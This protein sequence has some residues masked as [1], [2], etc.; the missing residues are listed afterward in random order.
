MLQA[1]HQQI[2][3]QHQQYAQAGLIPPQT[4]LLNP[5]QPQLQPPPPFITPYGQYS[6]PSTHRR[7]QSSI[8]PNHH[9]N[10]G[11]NNHQANA[12][13]SSSSGPS[14]GHN[15][16]HSLALSEAKQAAAIAQ[17]KRSN[18]SDTSSAS[19]ETPTSSTSDSKPNIPSF[20]FPSSP[21]KPADTSSTS[22]P[23][24]SP[25][26]HG[27]SQSLQYQRS[28]TRNTSPQRSYQFPATNNTSASEQQ[29]PQ[30]QQQQDFSRSHQHNRSGSRNFDG[31]WRQ[32]HQPQPSQD[33]LSAPFVPGHR[34]RGSYGNSV[35]SIQAYGMMNQPQFAPNGAPGNQQQRKSLFSPY[36]PQASL[37]AL[38]AEGRLVS[39]ILRVNKKNRSDAYVS[40]DGLLDAD[41][42]ICGSKDRNRALEGDL[43]AVELLEVDE[44]WTSKKEK[45]EKKKRKDATIN[46]VEDNR[47]PLSENGGLRRRGSLK[48]R[49]T[50][51]KNDDVEVEGQ[52]L[53]LVEEEA[54]SD[55]VKPLY[56]GHVVAIIDRVPA[57]TFSGT[58]GLLRPSSQATK[59][60]QDAERK[61]RGEGPSR[62][63]QDKPKIVWF[64][65]TDKRVPLIAIPT[66][67]A[68]SDF[69]EN[70]ESYV[71]KIF[72]ASIKR[73][74]IT[75]L[76]PFGTMGSL[77]GAAGD[78]DIEIEAL[79]RD[80]NFP[81]D[82]FSEQ[83]LSSVPQSTSITEEDLGKR[84]NLNSEYVLGFAP[85]ENLVEQAFHVTKIADDKV[86]I[87]I[88]VVDVSHYVEENSPLDHEARKRG[89]SV[90]LKQ[91][92]VNQFPDKFNEFVSFKAGRQSLALSVIFD[93]DPKTFIISDTW[94]GETIVTPSKI[95]PYSVGQSVLAKEESDVAVSQAEINYIHT[96]QAVSNKFR[97]QRL[98]L[99]EDDKAP[100]HAL[101]NYVDDENVVVS[102]NIFEGTLIQQLFDEINIKV[103]TAVAQKL[104]ATI[105][106]KAF[107]RRHA[108]PIL[109][110]IEAFTESVKNLNMEVDTATSAT[111][112][113]SFLS[114]G[115]AGIRKGLEALLYKCMTRAKYFIA[116]K[117]DA[118]NYGH[119]FF[120]VPVYTHFNAPLR[121]YADIVV[122]RQL[123][124]IINGVPY[125]E[126]IEK[127][128]T[129]ADIC[130][131]K[132][133]CAK[134]AQEQSIH[135]AVCQDIDKKTV[136]TGQLVIDSI[137]IQV[138]ESAFDV[139]IP[140]YGIEKRVHGDQLPLRKAEFDKATRLLELY[141]EGGID[142]AM[143]V[144]DNEKNVK[145]AAA[146]TPVRRGRVRASSAASAL[147]QESGGL[148]SIS[149]LSINKDKPSLDK[150]DAAN[151]SET[152][153]KVLAPY[154]ENVIKREEN[155]ERVQEIRVLQHV[156]VLLSAEL[157]NSI[158]CL[159]VRAV[160]PFTQ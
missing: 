113:K 75:S 79:L 82:I 87:G 39:G 133:D 18:L 55:E 144:P 64:K 105:G 159:T 104:V 53:L 135:L 91:R 21:D 7:V 66:D 54:L 2:L 110:K 61:D 41:I 130:N 31:N 153:G 56:A 138:Y 8:P 127:L 98:G 28:F 152:A 86:E 131:F 32:S 77:L 44:V 132:K 123:K 15:R 140:E 148:E 69:V 19:P 100:V 57:Q 99:D 85:K 103:N 160:N 58:L 20:K 94:I 112:Q 115:D 143:Y 76:H 29:Q 134:N 150:S 80:N 24:A 10:S 68:P 78:E 11:G 157:G 118:D 107:L 46:S 156:P 136:A 102:S 74:P 17:A 147:A 59:N 121:R 111:I 6:Q 14:L 4:N 16:R 146:V 122:H 73:W 3:A 42:F 65:P 89:T 5:Q 120:N 141:W 33:F 1:Q 151:Y 26:R 109:Q 108:D 139:L 129:I 158:P 154:F 155:G 92:T 96:L 119:Y 40:T 47:Q 45:E 52:S 124:A 142:S 23:V 48:Q 117:T 128:S 30:Q 13:T 106:D 145:N 60:K 126:D 67:Q 149:K 50:Q 83:V 137:V 93:I 12:S 43:V 22:S 25:S 95:I 116:G 72:T 27:R 34:S 36:L 9:S 88:H 84:R 81:A 90:F 38:L 37:P 114:T 70:H 35:S 49:P 71:D 125:D 101:L 63:Y 62:P 51:K 97:Q